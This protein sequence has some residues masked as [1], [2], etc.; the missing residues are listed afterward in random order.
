M[1]QGLLLLLLFLLSSFR[2][3]AL[4]NWALNPPSDDAM[5]FYSVG[6]GSSISEAR[7]HALG[8][9]AARLKVQIQSS[10]QQFVDAQQKQSPFYLELDIKQVSSAFEF[11]RVEDLRSSFDTDHNVHYVLT[12]VNKNSFFEQQE[13]VLAKQ[14]AHFSELTDTETALKRLFEYNLLKNKLHSELYLLKAYNIEVEDL[15]E[16]L[17][18]ADQMFKKLAAATPITINSS[19]VPVN[20]IIQGWLSKA[21]FDLFKTSDDANLKVTTTGLNTWQGQDKFHHA[22]KQEVTLVFSYAGQILLTR[23]LSATAYARAQEQA[24]TIAWQ[25][26]TEQLET[27]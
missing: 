17:A 19:S 1:K 6:S 24:Q 25:R 5:W 8:E 26:L 10:S 4:P 9:I 11:N 18:K 14:L 12:R 2:A 27:N 20:Q 22:I 7:K 3:L 21:G 13:Q 15:K 16:S 23:D